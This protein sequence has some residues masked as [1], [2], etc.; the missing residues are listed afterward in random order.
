MTALEQIFQELLCCERAFIPPGHPAS[1][2]YVEVLN[3][4]F[5]VRHGRGRRRL[6]PAIRAYN[7]K[8]KDR[9]GAAPETIRWSLR[10]LTSRWTHIAALGAI[11]RMD[12]AEKKTLAA[13]EELNDYIQRAAEW[14][15][16]G[17]LQSAGGPFEGRMGPIRKAFGGRGDRA[18]MANRQKWKRGAKMQ[19]KFGLASGDRVFLNMRRSLR[20]QLRHLH[21]KCTKYRRQWAPSCASGASRRAWSKQSTTETAGC[22]RTQLRLATRRR[23]PSRATLLRNSCAQ[24]QPGRA[25]RSSGATHTGRPPGRGPQQ[26]ARKGRQGKQ[27]GTQTR[28]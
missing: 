1:D 17:T 12:G 7:A 26:G 4:I 9:I 22:A 5:F 21:P 23:E 27:V 19:N 10:V 15:K 13:K 24:Q 6:A 11:R 20:R 14:E 2:G 25:S 16:G 8:I 18:D 28:R 3:R